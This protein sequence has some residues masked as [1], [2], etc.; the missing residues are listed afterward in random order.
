VAISGAFMLAAI[1]MACADVTLVSGFPEPET[2]VIIGDESQTQKEFPTASTFKMIIA[3]AAFDKG[4]ANLD[5]Q[6]ICS[7]EFLPSKKPRLLN[8]QQAMYYS[9]NQYFEALLQKLKNSDLLEMAERCHFGKTF[10]DPPKDIK[11][12]V[13]GGSIRVTPVEEHEFMR[14]LAQRKLPV[15]RKIQDKLIQAMTWP[16]TSHGREVHGKT[17]SV[18]NTYWFNGF[19]R[20]ADHIRVITVLHTGAAS[21]RDHAIQAFY[22]EAEKPFGG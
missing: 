15:E 5:T 21:S 10:G 14:R 22:R 8:F 18:R 7:D 17:G 11:E 2:A 9:S 3:L 20:D 13:H 1:S 4:T 6:T 12:W 19:C 16:P